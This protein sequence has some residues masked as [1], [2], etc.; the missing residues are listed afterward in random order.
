[1]NLAQGRCAIKHAERETSMAQEFSTV[2]LEKVAGTGVA[3]LIFNRPHK[4]NALDAQLVKDIM[5]ALEEIRADREIN[6]V[7][8]RGNGPV[9]CSGLDLYYLRAQSEGPPDDWDR[10]SPTAIMFEA[11]EKLCQSHHRPGSW[12]LSRRRFGFDELPRPCY[13]GD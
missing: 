5:S 11:V 13:R 6:V 1:M 8:T 2:I 3:K 9:Y 7:V 10:F 4:R 12:V